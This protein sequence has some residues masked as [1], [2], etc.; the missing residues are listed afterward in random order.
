V[1]KLGGSVLTSSAAYRR[2]AQFLAKRIHGCPEEQIV[3]VASAQG[4]LTDTLERV[5]QD[6]TKREASS[7]ASAIP[8]N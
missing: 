3:A 1:V 7:Y 6:N 8:P 2:A 5:A 4:G